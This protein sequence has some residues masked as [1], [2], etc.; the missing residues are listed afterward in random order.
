[1]DHQITPPCW[2][3]CCL[4]PAMRLG[5]VKVPK[6]SRSFFPRANARANRSRNVD[7]QVSVESPSTRRV[8]ADGGVFEGVPQAFDFD[9][10]VTRQG[11]M[12]LENPG[13]P[14]SWA[15]R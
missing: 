12:W 6:E 7:R 10:P 5:M 9:A 15:R 4:H 13:P 2:G 3:G 14:P 8:M 1:M 11:V